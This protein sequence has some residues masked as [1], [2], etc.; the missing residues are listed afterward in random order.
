MKSFCLCCFNLLNGKLSYLEITKLGFFF[1][2][3]KLQP[4]HHMNDSLLYPF[5]MSLICN[6]CKSG[7]KKGQEDPLEEVLCQSCATLVAQ[8]LNH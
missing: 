3:P 7:L 8:F 2:D 4:Q 6:M 5:Q 1:L